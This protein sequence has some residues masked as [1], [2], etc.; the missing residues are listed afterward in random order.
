MCRAVCVGLCKEGGG[1]FSHMVDNM[2]QLFLCMGSSFHLR[3]D[4]IVL[5]PNPSVGAW[6]GGCARTSFMYKNKSVS[7]FCTKA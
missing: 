5:Y 4:M 2:H 6:A 1:L 7:N 3:F